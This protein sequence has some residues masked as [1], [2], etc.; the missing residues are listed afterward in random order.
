MVWLRAV[1]GLF[2]SFAD[3][4]VFICLGMMRHLVPYVR[5]IDRVGVAV[6][7]RVSSVVCVD[8][9]CSDRATGSLTDRYRVRQRKT[10]TLPCSLN[11][12]NSLTQ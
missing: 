7:V 2:E 11:R 12:R 6:P 10:N 3:E 8:W 5:V 4:V 1:S 9:S